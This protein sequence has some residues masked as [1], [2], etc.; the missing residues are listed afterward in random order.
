MN[1]KIKFVWSVKKME[2]YDAKWQFE[3]ALVIFSVD[4]DVLLTI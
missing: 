3:R 2:G 1:E 4:A